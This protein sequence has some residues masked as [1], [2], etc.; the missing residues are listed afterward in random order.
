MD[1]WI[2]T[3]TAGLS[4]STSPVSTLVLMDSWIKTI[5]PPS[6]LPQHLRFNPCFN[7]FMD[8]D[9]SWTLWMS[10][11]E[12]VSTLVLMDSWIKTA[13][14]PKPLLPSPGFNPCFNG[15]MDKDLCTQI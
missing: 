11:P 14:A 9:Q 2:K 7:G 13:R 4:Y 3:Q 10:W 12:M 5:P 8:K 1:S 15:F 6:A